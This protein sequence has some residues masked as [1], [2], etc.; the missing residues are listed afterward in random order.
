MRLLGALSGGT[1]LGNGGLT[2][3]LLDAS[4][5]LKKLG[6]CLCLTADLGGLTDLGCL[7]G[8]LALKHN[9]GDEA[10]D[11]GSLGVRLATF[12]LNGTADNSLGNI[13]FLGKVEELADVAGTLGTKTAGL[14]DI[15]QTRELLLALLNNNK[16]ENRE[17][18]ASDATSDRLAL[19]FTS[20][21]R[22]V[23]RV[24]LG[25]EETDT[26]VSEDT[27]L[28]AETL[29]VVTTRDAEDVTLVFVTKDL[30]GNLGRD[31]LIHQRMKL[32]IVINLNEL[33]SPRGGVGNVDLH[34]R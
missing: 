32:L 16:V 31:A 8:S 26:T 3:L 13:V 12:L 1:A 6:V 27:L 34:C 28:H 22:T 10:L 4:T 33:L 15:S 20:A 7:T 25:E 29:L 30:T 9:R 14:G 19:A 2:L 18:H 24:T 11:L 5:L 17:V 21:A 23:A